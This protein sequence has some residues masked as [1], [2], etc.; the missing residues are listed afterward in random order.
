M[1]QMSPL[2]WTTLFMLM[3]MNMLM[4]MMILYFMKNMTTK[5]KE[6]S[7]KMNKKNWT[8]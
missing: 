2:W 4:M 1:P 5:I 3:N 8:W 6:T 7:T